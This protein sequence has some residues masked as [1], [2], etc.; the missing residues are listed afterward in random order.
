[1]LN[2]DQLPLYSVA[3]LPELFLLDSQ[4]KFLALKVKP[5]A[6]YT[7]LHAIYIEKQ[8]QSDTCV[9]C[10]LVTVTEWQGKSEKEEFFL[11]ADNAEQLL[12][13]LQR[14]DEID[15]FIFMQIPHSLNMEIVTMQ[16]QAILCLLFPELGKYDQSASKEALLSLKNQSLALLKRL[17]K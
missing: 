9:Y 8:L 4:S 7:V 6:Q 15:N 2:V 1:M 3:S 16:P 11:E 10:A 5:E 14:F 13:K 12:E 17:E